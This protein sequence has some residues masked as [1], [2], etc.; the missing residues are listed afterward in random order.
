MFS[1]IH[2]HTHT[3]THTHIPKTTKNLFEQLMNS[4]KLQDTKFNIKGAVFLHTNNEFYRIK[5]ESNA[6]YNSIKK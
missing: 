5:K 4:L 2:T 1:Y 3:H 6:I